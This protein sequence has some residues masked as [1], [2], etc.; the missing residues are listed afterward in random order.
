M[1][2]EYLRKIIHAVRLVRISEAAAIQLIK[3]HFEQSNGRGRAQGCDQSTAEDKEADG[4]RPA[5]CGKGAEFPG[6]C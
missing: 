1:H 3:Q 4:N 2:D 5:A 6:P